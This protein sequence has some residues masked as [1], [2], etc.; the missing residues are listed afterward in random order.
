VR[1]SV[2]LARIGCAEIRLVARIALTAALCAGL[3]VAVAPDARATAP[4]TV[5]FTDDVYFEAPATRDAWIQRTVATGAGVVLL[6]V[7]WGGAEPTPARSADPNDPVYQ[8]GS[9]DTAVRALAA[10]GVPVALMVTDAPGWAEGAHR[11]RGASAGTWKPDAGAYGRFAAAIAA[12]YSGTFADPAAPA[13]PLPRVRYWQAWA[14][15]NLTV[16]LAPQ[17]TGTGRRRQPASPAIYR[18]LLN[19]FYAGV[20]RAHADNVVVTAG[21]APFGDSPGGKRMPPATF[22]RELLCLHG[23]RLRAARCPN[24]AHFDALA[25]HPYEVAA[26]TTKALSPDD[27]TAPDLGKLTRIVRVAVRRGRALPRARKRLW[28]TEFSYD[29]K[30]PNPQAVSQATQARWLEQSFYVF[31]RQGADAVVWYLIRDQAPIP[32]YASAYESGVYLRDGRPK[33]SLR[34][35]QFP[36]VVQP[37]GN[38]LV[39]WGKSPVAGRL[40]VQRQQ[41]SRW[42]SI[43]RVDV[44]K[45]GVFLRRIATRGGRYRAVVGSWTSLVWRQR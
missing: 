40:Q 18:G 12:R 38:G 23:R 16:H 3:I 10:A 30:P 34:A 20:K 14:E 25:H 2:T 13:I 24:P 28:V 32:D 26:P 9:T 1:R 7:D 37:R 27:V 33:V 41:G 42:I 36:F 6:V 8:W 4:L 11:P 29:S 43:A 31:W 35:F 45:G 19:A 39:A 44:R 15:P 22:V 5:G 17:W 21:T